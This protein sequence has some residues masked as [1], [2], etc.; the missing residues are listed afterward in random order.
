MSGWAL[1][2]HLQKERW[3]ACLFIVSLVLADC[4]WAHKQQNDG[5][6]SVN[7]LT[8]RPVCLIWQ[9]QKKYLLSQDCIKPKLCFKKPAVIVSS[10]GCLFSRELGGTER[11]EG[12]RGALSFS[13][14]VRA[15]NAEKIKMARRK[16]NEQVCC[17]ISQEAFYIQRNL[18]RFSYVL[19]VRSWEVQNPYPCQLNIKRQFINR[20]TEKFK[21]ESTFSHVRS[22]HLECFVFPP[23]LLL[24]SLDPFSPNAYTFSSSS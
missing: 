22:V 7:Q 24:S 18:N 21:D 10:L 1:E 23:F 14:A 20:G 11:R 19:L 9:L 17:W 3:G 15:S 8:H 5:E 13:N 2:N 6:I 16:W 12:V 4:Q